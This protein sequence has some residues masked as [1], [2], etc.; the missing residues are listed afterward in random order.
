M[1]MIIAAII[2]FL[3]CRHDE[4]SPSQSNNRQRQIHSDEPRV[5]NTSSAAVSEI[6]EQSERSEISIGI[7]EPIKMPPVTPTIDNPST[8][9][10]RSVLAKQQFDD[11]D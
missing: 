2:Y 1:V 3:K 6:I 8:K 9:L 4:T 11:F 10:K 7:N 5:S